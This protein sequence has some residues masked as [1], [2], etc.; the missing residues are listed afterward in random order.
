M[1]NQET[2][3]FVVSKIAPVPEAD[4]DLVAVDLTKARSW[5]CLWNGHCGSGAAQAAAR[6]K[7]AS[8]RSGRQVGWEAFAADAGR[9]CTARSR[10]RC[11]RSRARSTGKPYLP[12]AGWYPRRL[13]IAAGASPLEI[14][15]G[16]E[17]GI[18]NRPAIV[19]GAAVEQGAGNLGGRAAWL[20]GTI[21]ELGDLEVPVAIVA[22]RAVLD[23][24]RHNVLLSSRTLEDP[25]IVAD[26]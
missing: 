20:G 11:H 10:Y 23:P 9:R 26:R 5:H 6:L 19:L 15:V 22:G 17:A 13:Q 1:S 8:R 12:L 16:Q 4:D 3:W 21:V 14:A 7:R 18:G 25:L 2:P 24:I